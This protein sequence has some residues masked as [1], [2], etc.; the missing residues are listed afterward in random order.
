MGQ[1]CALPLRGN[2]VDDEDKRSDIVLHGNHLECPE[3]LLLYLGRI[4]SYWYLL[5]IVARNRAQ[6]GEKWL[7]A[8]GFWPWYPIPERNAFLLKCREEHIHFL[9]GLILHRQ[10]NAECQEHLGTDWEGDMISNWMIQRWPNTE[11]WDFIKKQP[12][13]ETEFIPLAFRDP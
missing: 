3:R 5:K 11:F 1:T 12:F 13:A 8:R 7:E 4:E 10:R 6:L 9:Y 2:N